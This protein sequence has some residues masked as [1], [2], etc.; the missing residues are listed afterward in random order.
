MKVIFNDEKP[1]DCCERPPPDFIVFG[2]REGRRMVHDISIHLGCC[3]QNQ[4]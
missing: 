4:V 3:F 2:E 1:Y